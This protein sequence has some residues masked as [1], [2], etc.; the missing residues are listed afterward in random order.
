MPDRITMHH[1]T[2]GNTLGHCAG[3]AI[4]GILLYLFFL[5]WRRSGRNRSGMSACVAA[6]MLLWN[7]GGLAMLAPGLQGNHAVHLLHAISFSAL[8]LVPAVLLHIWLQQR[9]AS[10]WFSGYV[11]SSVAVGIHLWDHFTNIISPHC[12][13]LTW[14][15]VGFSGLTAIAV[16]LDFR[17]YRLRRAG[18]RLVAAMSL[19]LLAISVVY[20]E[21]G[22]ARHFHHFGIPLAL[23]VL[24]VDYRFLLLGAF[25]RFAVMSILAS[26]IAFLGFVAQSR[27]HFIEHAATN[28][29]EAGLAF[30]CVCIILAAF[31]KVSNMVERLFTGLFFRRP[32]VETVLATLRD[33]LTAQH[34]EEQ[35][36]NHAR[37]TIKTFFE[38]QFS[39]FQGHL[40]AQDLEDLPGPVPLLNK[41]RW[42]AFLST[43]WAE[44]AL[45]LRFFRGDALLLL[46]GPRLG[47]RPYLTDDLA[48]LE[49]FGKI[50]E[51]QVERKRHLHMRALASE[52]EMRALQ[53]QINPHFFFN[54]LNTLYGTIA[55]TNSEARH[56]VLNLADVFRYFLRSNR[57][58]IT[59]EEELK[60]I[61]AYLEIEALRLGP[62]L[63]TTIHVDKALLQAEIPVLSIQPLVE[64]AV[65]YG[66]APHS[67]KGFVRLTVKSQDNH[68]KVEVVNTGELG[69]HSRNGPTDG[70]GLANLRRRLALCYGSESELYISSKDNQTFVGFSIPLGRPGWGDG[71]HEDTTLKTA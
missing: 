54:S 20:F 30:V 43:P 48:L 11:L 45:P 14:V 13:A 44:A 64:N 2:L 71:F 53:A 62:R 41:S 21:T 6:L 38:C 4:F 19:L 47:R 23:F 28:Q 65:K 26:G 70:I 12:A 40:K 67:K 69:S 15:A 31:V 59:L 3:I 60:I 10:L 35:Y 16:V 22:H 36:L 25:L 63:A 42:P 7:I 51:E 33:S 37:Q 5:D 29:F 34:A 24:L 61:R 56:L 17:E 49:R 32:R 50:V 18:S 58:F 46:L 9:Y 55:R 68:L 52:A 57:T 1:G 39:R 27:L 8:S 66:V